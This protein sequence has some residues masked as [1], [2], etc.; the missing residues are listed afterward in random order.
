MNSRILLYLALLIINSLHSCQEKQQ[1]VLEYSSLVIRTVDPATELELKSVRLMRPSLNPF[2]SIGSIHKI[3]T[4][5]D[6]IIV[7][8]KIVG[9][10]VFIYDNKGNY[11]NHI[12]RIG[13]GPGEYKNVDN[14][15]YNPHLDLLV[16]IPM[17]L[18]RKIYF[19]L[20][21]NYVR[22]ERFEPYIYYSDL[23]FLENGELLINNSS[24]NGENS[25]MLLQNDELILTEFPYISYLDNTPLDQRNLIS[26]V[27][28]D[29][30][31]FTVG[32]RDTI[33]QINAKTS[34]V[35]VAY[36]FDM[37]NPISKMDLANHPNPLKYFLDNDI[38]VGV[39]DIFQ[40]ENFLSFSTLSST[41]LKGRLLNKDN[42]KLFD[43]EDL[44]KSYLGDLKF[45]G[46]LGLS[47]KG[48]FIAV[49]NAAEVRKWDFSKNPELEAQFQKMGDVDPEELLLLF[50]DLEAK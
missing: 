42:F 4:L 1:E 2:A 14:V 23:V 38:Y 46:I 25:L 43:T 50:F 17:D 36:V 45:Q 24:M 39:I 22:E 7:V 10:A 12:H 29:H 9:N 33:Y 6:R 49:I 3:L 20:E 44:I 32:D 35:T 5:N 31:F 8:D 28:E 21:G 34:E 48:E 13:Q 47:L 37:E 41:G 15:Y 26:K 16:L 11:I 30:Y 27:R 19:D 18:G 40:N